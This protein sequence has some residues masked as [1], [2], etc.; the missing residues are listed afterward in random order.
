M[1]SYEIIIT[2]RAAADF[3]EL[4]DYIAGVLCSP[5]T[6]FAY[7]N[8]LQTELNTLSQMPE[9]IRPIES[10]PWYSKSIRRIL[11]KNFY[12][13]YLISK[14]DCCVYVV[15]IIYSKRDQLKQ[16]ETIKS[17]LPK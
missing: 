2:P 11:I 9:R 10:E 15:S 5:E 1:I 7:I 14:D 17:T 6:A 3:T 16:L 4:H 8:A 13:Y 12:A